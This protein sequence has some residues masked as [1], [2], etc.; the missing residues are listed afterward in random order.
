MIVTTHAADRMAKNDIA[1]FEVERLL[2]AAPVVMVDTEPDGTETWRVTG[3]DTDGRRIAV[4]IEPL[5][6]SMAVVI[7]VI[8]LD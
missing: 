2:K 1:R 5:P 8:G 7:T 3:H 6:P 4:V